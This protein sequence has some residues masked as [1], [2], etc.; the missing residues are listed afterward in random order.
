MCRLRR[1]R[2]VHRRIGVHVRQGNERRGDD[3]FI[4]L[5]LALRSRALNLVD[6]RIDEVETAHKAVEACDSLSV[7]HRLRG[8]FDVLPRLAKLFDRE[9]QRCAQLAQLVGVGAHDIDDANRRTVVIGAAD[10]VEGVFVERC[11][12]HVFALRAVPFADLV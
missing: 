3:I 11:D 7:R 9:T 4:D 6:R 10:L 5:R 1:D 2:H 8:R 12:R